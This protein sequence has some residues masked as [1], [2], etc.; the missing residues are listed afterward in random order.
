MTLGGSTSSYAYLYSE[1][2]SGLNK[3]TPKFITT[4]PTFMSADGEYRHRLITYEQFDG[5]MREWAGELEPLEDLVVSAVESSTVQTQVFS[6]YPKNFNGDAGKF[7]ELLRA[8]RIEITAMVSSLWCSWWYISSKTSPNH[9]N[10]SYLTIIRGLSGLPAAF[11]ES[12]SRLFAKGE[13]EF[14]DRLKSLG[15]PSAGPLGYRAEAG[16]KIMVLSRADLNNYS[17]LRYP[18]W[19]EVYGNLLASELLSNYYTPCVPMFLQ[20]FFI[21]NSNRLLFDNE[22]QH[23]RFINAEV[24]EDVM[25]LLKSADDRNFTD[26]TSGAYRDPKFQALSNRIRQIMRTEGDAARVA[27]TA[28]GMLFEHTGRTIGDALILLEHGNT[29]DYAPMFLE[30]PMMFRKYMFEFVYT[31][32]CFNRKQRLFHGDLH[33][34]NATIYRR[35]PKNREMK[36]VYLV[37]DS[38]NRPLVYCLPYNGAFACIIDFS[39]CILGDVTRISR[40]FTPEY[41]R[42]FVSSQG[43]AIATMFNNSF[44]ELYRKY[45]DRLMEAVRWKFDTAFKVL[46]AHDGYRLT[47][48]IYSMLLKVQRDFTRLKIHP[49]VL[50]IASGLRDHYADWYNKYLEMLTSGEVNSPEQVPWV[51]LEVLK[52]HFTM[53]KVTSPGDIDEQRGELADVFSMMHPM[54]FGFRTYESLSP[55]LKLDTVIEQKNLHGLDPSEDIARMIAFK[56]DASSSIV[57]LINYYRDQSSESA[58]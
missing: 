52:A 45:S 20:Y 41:A 49:D 27:D 38:D 19:R 30:D 18:C 33:I 53:F 4:C 56:R 24:T 42:D 25:K 21:Q 8:S 31:L 13:T 28:L 16:Q 43:D 17:D 54:N 40:D 5:V 29:Q 1:Y 37:E 48:E 47:N 55:L 7:D 34:N 36:I 12:K 9:I 44:P 11:R 26:P 50:K 15:Q 23:R 46:C 10:E 51:H 14:I 57:N 32:Y 35:V 39:R 22:P 2:D 3:F 6:F 58:S